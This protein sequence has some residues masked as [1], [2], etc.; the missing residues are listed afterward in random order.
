MSCAAANEG[1]AV[2]G[3][4]EAGVAEFV[5]VVVVVVHRLVHLREIVLDLLHGD[6]SSASSLGPGDPAWVE[7]LGDLQKTWAPVLCSA[8]RARQP[9][10]IRQ[11]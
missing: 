9:N 4:L 3:R 2:E 8:F 6:A 11:R 1:A 5:V 7:A 10:Q